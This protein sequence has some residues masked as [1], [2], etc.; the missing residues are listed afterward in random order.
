MTFDLGRSRKTRKNEDNRD[1]R[2]N[3]KNKAFTKI[4]NITSIILCVLVIVGRVATSDSSDVERVSY[5][6][7][8][9]Q[10][11]NGEIDTVYIDSG[12]LNV[13]YTLLS[14]ETRKMTLDERNKIPYEDKES[15]ITDYPANNYEFTAYV[16]ENDAQLIYQDFSNPMGSILLNLIL[17]FLPI[18][19]FLVVMYKW[20]KESMGMGN[21]KTSIVA[22]K[23]DVKFSDIIGH[24]EAIK[25]IKQ[26]LQIMI[27]ASKY[28]GM[29][30]K[31]PKGMLLIGPPGTGK[32]MIAQA[33]ANE[34]NMSFFSVNS[35]AIIDRFVGMGAKNIRDVFENARKNQPAILFLDEIDAIGRS[36]NS[37]QNTSEHQQTLNALLQELD[38]FQPND[39]VYIM[40]ATN[41]YSS[42]DPALIRSGRFDRKITINPPRDSQTRKKLLEHYLDGVLDETINLDIIAKQLAGFT[43]SDINQICNEAKIIAI[44]HQKKIVSQEFLEEAIEK[45]LFNGNRT[46]NEY[47]KDL[48]IVANHESGHA[49]CMLLNEMPIARISVI[50]NTSGVGGMVIQQDSDTLFITKK[51]LRKNIKSFYAGRIA[52]ELIYGSEDITSGASNDLEQANKLLE[53]YLNDF[54]FDSTYGLTS[55]GDKELRKR[56]SELAEQIYKEAKE[57]LEKHKDVLINMAKIV[58]EKETIDGDEL[59]KI[60]EELMIKYGFMENKTSK[61]NET[62]DKSENTTK[63][64][65]SNEEIEKTV[66]SV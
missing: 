7:F 15:Y 47:K 11:E 52:E 9:S 23:S 12:N 49:L 19:I 59:K 48:E 16:L 22:K 38:G 18:T 20:A 53:K 64:V 5:K 62:V 54:A 25:D 27:D 40:A 29:N 13:R 43:G 33:T 65:I 58:L 66:E 51:Q 24:D 4:L 44:M 57:E 2:N 28:E 14:D 17:N 60:Y 31:A 36:R 61:E 30:V 21:A 45:T 42:L 50:P 8:Q 3:K 32:T 39:Q 37:I 10:L 63:K 41:M 35:S 6:T 34:A 46:K 56:K 55:L 1:D 26:A